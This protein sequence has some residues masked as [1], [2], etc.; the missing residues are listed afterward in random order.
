[1]ARRKGDSLEVV[2]CRRHGKPVFRLIVKRP[3]L[4]QFADIELKT[5]DAKVLLRAVAKMLAPKWEVTK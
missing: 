5:G 3:S 4:D 2:E 1:M